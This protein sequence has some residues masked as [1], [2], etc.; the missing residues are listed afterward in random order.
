MNITEIK[1]CEDG[2]LEHSRLSDREILKLHSRSRAALALSCLLPV[3]CWLI[4]SSA[5][6]QRAPELDPA[7]ADKA[8]LQTHVPGVDETETFISQSTWKL[9]VGTVQKFGLVTSHAR[10]QKD[11]KPDSRFITVLFDGRIG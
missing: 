10:F 2:T 1:I 3:L 6:A 11:Q 9:P 4:S 5:F 7:S 8:S